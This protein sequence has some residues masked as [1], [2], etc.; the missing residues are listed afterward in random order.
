MCRLKKI[1]LVIFL[2]LISKLAFAQNETFYNPLI[3]I[4]EEGEKLVKQ[5]EKAYK[6]KRYKE[7]IEI[8]KKISILFPLT[9]KEN[10][11]IAESYLRL[12]YPQ[13][14]IE[15]ANRVLFLRKGTF[16]AC[17]AR[18]IQLESL[19]V[20][21]QLKGIKKQIKNYLNSFCGERFGNQAKALLHY[22]GIK[23]QV[24]SKLLR[25][26][27]GKVVKARALYLLRN[28]KP[29]EARKNLFLY[30]NV[31]GNLEDASSLFFELAEVYFKNHQREK[32][33]VL[34]KLIITQWEGSKEAFLSKFRLYQIAY[35]QILIKELV[36]KE[37]IEALLSY[38]SQI[39][40]RYPKDKIAKEAHLLEL[41][42]Y[43][44]YK[45]YK[46]LRK[47]AKQ[48]IEKYPKDAVI[49]KIYKYYCESISNIFK[50]TYEQKRFDK[51]FVL[52]EEDRKF[53]KKT[54][55]GYPY[56]IL[57]N[58]FLDYNFF[59]YASYEFIQAQ[60]LG[61]DKK[62]EPDLLLKLSLV[63][64]ETGEEQLFKKLFSLIISK[65]KKKLLKKD[66]F[67]LY[68]QTIYES[69]KDFNTAQ[70]YLKLALNSNLPQ[71]YKQEL[72]KFF[73]DRALIL[74]NYEK[75]LE[76]TEN[77]LFKA[78]PEDFI[79]LLL[80][81]FE[82]NPQIFEKIL[83]KAKKRF[84]ENFRIKWIEA[85][86]LEKHGKIKA[87]DKIWQELKKG[88]QYSSKIAE[89]YEKLKKLIEKTY[90]LAF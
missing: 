88:S 31:Y 56:Y 44:Q 74:K 2:I 85:Y 65:Y 79:L 62:I 15:Y 76:Y 6:R 42:I 8:S 63:A 25:D 66:P 53:L 41:E 87:A 39:K 47:S 50:K 43:H 54:N 3:Q 30:L 81:S 61:V 55:C 10:L 17:E 5:M 57:G 12:G 60:E 24:N 38:I 35:E 29:E 18:L 23:N 80:S 20:L 68:L 33:K 84:P 70:N 83:K 71:F 7:V 1:L 45:N 34:Y 90:N 67:Y 36:P 27:V 32:A 59:S 51:L 16:E 13:K 14:A 28:N 48:F 4:Q 78:Q 52:E 40:T 19:I 49:K 22:L 9:A 75:A 21:N 37:T 89:S 73:R 46:L 26:E 86:Y 11:M 58:V 77:P 69:Y 64:H 82:N 72:L